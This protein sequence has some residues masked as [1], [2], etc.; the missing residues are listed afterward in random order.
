MSRFLPA[1]VAIVLVLLCGIVHGFW[2]DRWM[3]SRAPA[4][5]AER[6]RQ[7]PMTA[8]DW[9]AQ[10]IPPDSRFTEAITGQMYRRYV[11]RTN[12]NV[13]TV[14]L[15]CGLPGP[16][17]I[18]TPDVCYKAGGFDVATPLK[19]TQPAQGQTPAADFL[20]SDLS[21]NRSTGQVYQ[22]IFWS[23][24]TTGTWRVPGRD[25]RFAF[26]SE[27]VLY[28]IYLIREMNSAGEPLEDDPCVDLMRQL[29]PQ[30]QHYLFS[31]P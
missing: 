30:F 9:Q 12:G 27:P 21:K 13:V 24:N 18:H 3:V 15:I 4:E 19:Y 5:A 29:L 26:P 28:K 22:R 1:Y 17:S 23:W 8:G 10:E 6:L 7:V 16:V 31:Q 20:T 14:A 2:T 11:N 25:P